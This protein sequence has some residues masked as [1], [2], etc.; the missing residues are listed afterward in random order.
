MKKIYLDNSASTRVDDEVV[1]AMLPCFTE[2]FGNASSTHQFGQHAKQAIEDARGQVARMLNASPPEITFLSGGTESDNLAVKGIAEAH[3][4]KGRHLITSQIEHPA[5]L[6][7][8]AHLEKR[9]WRVTYLPVYREGIV[10]ID[11]VREALTDETTLITVMHAN[12]EIGTIQPLQEIAALIRERR[13]AGQRHLHLHT[14]AVQSVG[15]IP[16]DVMELGVDLLTLTAHKFHGPKG[17]GALYVRKGVRL[18]SQMH[19]GHHE[20]DRRAGTES[21]PLIVGIGKAAELVRLHLAERMEQA[22]ELRDTL[23]TEIFRRIPDVTRNGDAERRVPNIANLNFDFVE[24]EGLQISLDLKGVAVSTGSACSSGSTEPS[25][26]LMAI[27]L[28]RD[29]GYGSLR[30]SFG[31]DNTKA[32]VEYVLEV[33]P[34]IIEKLRKLSPRLRQRQAAG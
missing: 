6:A 24:G 10:R 17:I 21:V 1:Q 14:D 29:N 26:V 11:D 20:R 23:E 4:D 31:K 12:N 33:L 13:E 15:K 19:G 25:H 22:R 32:D 2:E 7:A 16:V 8:C 9:G 5:V 3:Q 27:G 28:P 30:F 18:T 34:A